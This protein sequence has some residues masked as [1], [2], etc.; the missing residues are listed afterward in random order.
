VSEL[1]KLQAFFILAGYTRYLDY[2]RFQ[3][4]NNRFAFS[5][6]K[7]IRMF[8]PGN[9]FV[10]TQKYLHASQYKDQSYQIYLLFCTKN[11]VCRRF[12]TGHSNL[13]LL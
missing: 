9:L 1:S 12:C 11:K 3:S 10:E 4:W 6:V 8:F 5:T 13:F 7:L 2:P